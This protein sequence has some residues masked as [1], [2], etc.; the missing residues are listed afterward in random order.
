MQTPRRAQFTQS[1]AEHRQQIFCS[2]DLEFTKACFFP[3]HK[4][5]KNVNDF[6]AVHPPTHISEFYACRLL[7]HKVCIAEI[8]GHHV[9]HSVH[10]TFYRFDRNFIAKQITKIVLIRCQS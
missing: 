3:L 8:F 6:N 5:T 10:H 2:R 4:G 1:T 9:L 7:V